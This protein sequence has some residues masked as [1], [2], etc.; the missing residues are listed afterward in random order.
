MEQF[1]NICNNPWCKCQFFY[2]EK[3]M[4]PNKNYNVKNPSEDEPEKLA[5]KE[6]PKCR[7]FNNNLSGG[8]EWKDRNYEGSRFDNTPHQIRYKV[9]NYK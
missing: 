4:I 1:R 6:C 2:T 8:V 9:T 3:E 7:S 5:P